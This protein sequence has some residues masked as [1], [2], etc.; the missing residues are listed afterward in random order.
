VKI[1]SQYKNRTNTET[2]KPQLIENQYDEVFICTGGETRTL[3][4][5]GTR[6]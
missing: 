4:P 2:K 3:T 1:Y 5:C 6:S